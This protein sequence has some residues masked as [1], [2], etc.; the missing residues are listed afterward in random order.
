MCSPRAESMQP[1]A[2][3]RIGFDH[4]ANEASVHPKSPR[5]LVRSHAL[6]DQ[7]ANLF[8]SRLDLLELPSAPTLRAR[9][10]LNPVIE[11]DLL[12]TLPGHAEP[13]AYLREGNP[14]VVE[15][16]HRLH[17]RRQASSLLL[18]RVYLP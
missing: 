3:L 7:V 15:V 13:G 8:E 5:H 17:P 9:T 12:D 6:F 11:K 18:S 1:A 10:R 2:Q 4:L 16:L 14:V